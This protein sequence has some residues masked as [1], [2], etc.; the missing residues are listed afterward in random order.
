MEEDKLIYSQQEQIGV[1]EQRKLIE[2]GRALNKILTKS[3]FT[4]IVVIYG[5]VV[6][7]LIKESGEVEA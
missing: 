5:G 6:E 3:E 1:V 2:L 4:D 7:R